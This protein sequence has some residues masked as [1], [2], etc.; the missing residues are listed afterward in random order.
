M[1]FTVATADV[2]AA[3]LAVAPHASKNKDDPSLHRIRCELDEHNL[4]I[5][6]TNRYTAGLA[7]ASVWELPDGEIGSFDLSPTDCA[8]L[9]ALFKGTSGDED[10]GDT[11]ELEVTGKEVVITDTGGLFNGKQLKLPRLPHGTS[12]PQLI[13]VITAAL[14]TPVAGDGRWI[15]DG[16]LLGLFSRA[17]RA[18]GRALT[19]APTERRAQL[20]SCG[21]SFLGLIQPIVNEE[22]DQ[23]VNGFMVDWQRRLPTPDPDLVTVLRVDPPPRDEAAE[24]AAEYARQVADHALLIDAAELV[25]ESQFGSVSMLQRKMRIGFAKA[26]HLMDRLEA[27]GVVGPSQGSR[28]RDVLVQP[29]QDLA[30][31]LPP[32]ADLR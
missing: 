16:G 20:V 13:Q 8:E 17:S 25:V 30:A 2:R 15:V 11:L 3:L 4:T 27:A 22:L 29:G 28:A 32:P 26:V 6:A 18:Y 12:F 21:E 1:R 19:I 14:H 5:T 7:I 10:R 31:L 23:E 9:L 24:A